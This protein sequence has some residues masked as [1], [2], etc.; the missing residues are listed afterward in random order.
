[1]P[2][3]RDKVSVDSNG[4]GRQKI[5]HLDFGTLAAIITGFYLALI[6]AVIK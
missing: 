6:M 1:M 2:L 3:F 5:A 4:R